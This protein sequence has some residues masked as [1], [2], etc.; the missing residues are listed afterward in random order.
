MSLATT[1]SP[2]D[3]QSSTVVMAIMND[4]RDALTASVA[5][6]GQ[7]TMTGALKAADGTITAPGYTFGSDTNTGLYR[8][9]SGVIRATCDGTNSFT[10]TA[11]GATVTG[12]FTVG[13]VTNAHVPAGVI[14]MWSGAIAAI[15]TGWLLCDGANGTP[16]LRDRFVIGARQDDAG[17]A[18]TNVTGSL[19]TT[20]GSKDAIVVSHTHT[21]SSNTTG[22]H[23]H[24]VT[25]PND[26]GV[27]PTG[28]GRSDPT[29]TQTRTT[30]SNGDHSHTITVDS[31]GDSGT[32]ANLPPYYALAFIMKA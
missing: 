7:S 12:T 19:T 8:S 30:S 23:T 5:T 27:H 26:S 17:A 16:D 31:A 29:T 20:G 13:A 6:D 25:G 11:T 1:I 24:T 22:A 4:V 3:S 9:A 18:K 15:P 14:V 2:G 21:A 32:N 28:S 10:M